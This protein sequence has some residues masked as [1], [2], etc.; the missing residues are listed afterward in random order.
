M[1]NMHI[2]ITIYLLAAEMYYTVVLTIDN[3]AALQEMALF[4]L[5]WRAYDCSNTTGAVQRFQRF[6]TPIYLIHLNL[7][8]RRL[9]WS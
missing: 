7:M 8:F 2:Q 5:T 3:C 1:Y 6:D 9:N 4:S